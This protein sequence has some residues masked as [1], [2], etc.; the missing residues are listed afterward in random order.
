MARLGIPRWLWI[1][2]LIFCSLALLGLLGTG[3]IGYR[4]GQ[5]AGNG[6]MELAATIAELGNQLN[7]QIATGNLAEALHLGE[8]LKTLGALDEGQIQQLRDRLH[9]QPAPEPDREPAPSPVPIQF[10]H[11]LWAQAQA[12]HATGEWVQTLN[13]LQQLREVDAQ[14]ITEPYIELMEETYIQWARE[15]VQ[16]NRGEEALSQ[17]QVA[18]A[19]RNTE[20]VQ[21][22]YNAAVHMVDSLSHWGVNWERSLEHLAQVYHYDS[23]YADVQARLAD[24]LQQYHASMSG[25]GAYCEAFLY[26]GSQ[27]P[28]LAE[29]E[30]TFLRDD[31]HHQCQAA[32]S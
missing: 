7:D 2:F 26:L 16:A 21:A 3:W 32:T 13:L 6:Q 29:L 17:L 10:R 12:A 5:I 1:F 15:L 25:R 14:Y 31:L 24:A 28:L 30:L 20:R 11:E 18:R 4:Q 19:L 22:E 23:G 8:Q 27:D 9:A